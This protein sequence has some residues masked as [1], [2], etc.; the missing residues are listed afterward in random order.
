M[1]RQIVLPLVLV[2]L[3]IGFWLS[4][5]F[6]QISAGV[7]IFL[8]GMLFLENG[9]RA[10]TGGVLEKLLDYTTD[11]LWKCISFGI[12]TTTILQSSSLVSVIT[13][14]FLSAGLIGLASGIGIIF[15]TNL[16]TTTGAWLIAGLGLKVNIAAYAMPMLVF[17]AILVFQKSKKRQGTGY[18][19]AGLGMLFLGIHHMKEGFAALESAV[20][21]AQFSM[22]GYPGLL[23]FSLVGIVATVIM[24]SSHATLVLIIT[25]LSVGQISYENALALAI[26]ANVGT[27]ITAIIAAMSADYRGKQLAVAHLIFNLVT[28]LIAI[29]F[30]WQIIWAVDGISVATGI[31]DTNYT[32]KLAVFHSLF[33]L[34]GVVLMAP[35]IGNMVRFLERVFPV[36]IPEIAEPKYLNDS[37]MDFPDTLI[38]A[39]YNETLYLYD[40]ALEILAHGLNVHRHDIH[41]NRD[42]RELLENERQ[43]IA[44]DLDERYNA[45][46]KGLY[47]AIISFVSRAQ[48]KVPPEF[49]ERIF[50]L[51]RASQHIVQS[52]KQIKHLRKNISTYIASHNDAIRGEYNVIRYRI[53][54]VLR[55]IHALREGD[56]DFSVFDLDDMKVAAEEENSAAMVN[57]DRMIR[58]EKIT[59]LM[60][61]SLLNDYGYARD[62][63]WQLADMAEILFSHRDATIRRAED[64]IGLEDEEIEELATR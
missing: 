46:V 62:A 59:P 23:V 5:D 9:F 54:M 26:G 64:L 17:G 39:L 28:G 35:F 19:L 63:V 50:E 48:T 32:L 53:I 6:K 3:A 52:V 57:I 11:S 7:A 21:L 30:I 43:I 51:R 27:T 61:T 4:P 56:K 29:I 34:T 18:I 58:E 8:F 31:S 22:S 60:A 15:G 33:N 40:N 41:S 1:I 47:S 14:S 13:I 12:V 38:E 55:A 25:A 42:L 49:S 10:F 16:G 24:Q 37:V 45:Q 2:L 20:D 36:P 44:F